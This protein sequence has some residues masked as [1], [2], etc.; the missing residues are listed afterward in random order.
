MR[1]NI[2]T[3]KY[4]IAI[5]L[6]V[7]TAV[8]IYRGE[9]RDEPAVEL[10][11]FSRSTG[12][13]RARLNALAKAVDFEQWPQTDARRV[14][15]T[16]DKS[17]LTQ[18]DLVTREAISYGFIDFNQVPRR[19]LSWSCQ[20]HVKTNEPLPTE[21]PPELKAELLENLSSEIRNDPNLVERYLSRKLERY[22]RTK[23]YRHEG[24]ML[25]RLCLAP[26]SRAA[27][28]YMLTMMTENTLPTEAMVGG[29]RTAE[30]PEGLGHISFLNKSKTKD[31]T[32]IMFVR[33]NVSL[34]IRGEG[35]FADDVLPL[36][37][38]IDSMLLGQPPLTYEQLL[39][40]RPS[41]TI[42]ANADKSANGEKTISYNISVPAGQEII[43]IKAYA[44]EE[45]QP[46]VRDG[47][48]YVNNKKGKIKVKLVATTSELLTNS[49]EIEVTVPE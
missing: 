10:R 6:I 30:R 2:S 9:P 44:N 46:P 41:I 28:E 47:K 36:A 37:R 48:I 39:A 32:R 7:I 22:R 5:L 4:L 1:A 11:C 40:R 21:L 31:Y 18:P 3:Q 25:V 19:R 38:K 33:D 20:R 24:L 35:C 26:S 8:L 42:A 49:D 14:A 15:V 27:Q 23:G 45:S 34:R 29:Y 16:I 12:S 43:D 17:L 13:D